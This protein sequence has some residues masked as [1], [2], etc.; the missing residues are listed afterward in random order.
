MSGFK[1]D[2]LQVLKERGFIHQ[3]SDE[4]GL[5]A[6]LSRE[7]TTCYIGFDATA[8]SLHAGSLVQ[9]MLLYW[10]QQ[11]G[12][13]PIALMGGGTTMIGDPSGKDESRKM[14][15]A[16]GIE[17]NK[18]GIKRVFSKFLKFERSRRNGH[19]GGQC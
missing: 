18:A 7:S 19:H 15:T 6:Q 11:T 16:E 10:F 5:D 9:I 4:S 1:S 14:L 2:F 12:H 17:E 8:P 13:R 3:I